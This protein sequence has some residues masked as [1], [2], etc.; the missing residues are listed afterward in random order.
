MVR[1]NSRTHRATP[2]LTSGNHALAQNARLFI[3]RASLGLHF[4]K[5]LSG[6]PRILSNLKSLLETGEIVLR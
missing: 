3:C 1:R 5:P 4:G 6:W 2:R